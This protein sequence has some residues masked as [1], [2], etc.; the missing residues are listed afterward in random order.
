MKRIRIIRYGLKTFLCLVFIFSCFIHAEEGMLPLSEIPGLDLKSLGFKI[1]AHELYNPNGVSLIDGIINLRGCTASFVSPD[2]L[3]LTNYHCSFRAVQTVTTKENDYMRDGFIAGDRGRELPAKGYTVRVIEFYRDVSADVLKVVKKKMTYAQRTRA[4]EKQIKKIEV[5]TEKKYPG[6]RADVAE[7]FIGKTYVLFVYTYLKDIRLVYAPPRS[8]GEYGGEI[9]N[10][11]WPRHTGDFAFMRAYTAADGSFA[12]YSPDNVPYHPKK[13]LQAAPEGV[14]EE[15]LVFILGYPG[16]TARH[17]TSYFIAFEEQVRMPWLVELYGWKINVLEK[18][19]EKDRT[20]EIKLSSKLKGLWNTMK[21]SQGQ[22]QGLKNLELVKK[23][24]E[25]ENALQAFIQADPRRRAKYGRLLER[26]AELFNEK[27]KDA[28]YDLLL[29]YLLRSSTML[30]NAYKVV[31]ASS[32]RKK[33]DT[34]RESAYMDRNFERTLKRIEINLGNYY[35]EADKILFKELL[36]RAAKPKGDKPRRIPA[37]DN[38]ILKDSVKGNHAAKEKAVDAF[39]D[40]AYNASRLNDKDVLMALFEKTRKEITMIEDPFIQLAVALY[41]T[42]REKKEKQKR[43]KGVLNELMSRFIDVKKEFIGKEFIP[44]A[45]STLRLTYGRIRGYSP[46][47]AVYYHPFTTLAG[48]IQKNTGKHP[49]NA[50]EKLIHLYGTTKPGPFTHPGLNDVPVA[51]LY[52][53]DTTGGNSGS[54]VLNAGGR[55]VGLNF[56]RVFEG[57]INDY[58]WDE[59]YSRSIGV[60]IRYILWFLEQFGGARHLLKEMNVH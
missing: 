29:D 52:N 57:T 28:Q 37:V 35:E 10:W 39:I 20:V 25:R 16:R 44:D 43:Q 22:L 58:A 18:L 15:D 1:D 34:E 3:I 7:M 51:M 9:D 42:Y 30:G 36:M 56:D 40:S 27:R 17:R 6:R 2:G 26:I 31:E 5:K 59:A 50:P 47:D 49:F 33:K 24:K 21:R 12:D 55:L 32:E 48:V 8:I 14:K 46:A 38:L 4:I 23:R 11:M 19:S 45:N 53:T 60:D 41:P 13:Y 54:P